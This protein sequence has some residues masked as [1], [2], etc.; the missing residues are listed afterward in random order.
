MSSLFS[1]FLS[2]IRFFTRN[3]NLN[4]VGASHLGTGGAVGW[5]ISLALAAGELF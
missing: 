1:G 2:L 3:S 5:R 4:Q